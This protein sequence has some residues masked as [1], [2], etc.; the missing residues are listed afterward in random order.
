MIERVDRQDLGYQVTRPLHH[1]LDRLGKDDP[2][3]V[4]LHSHSTPQSG[5]D[6]VLTDVEIWTGGGTEV[7]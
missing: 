5:A 2:D 1:Q 3:R 4:W 6:F 7:G